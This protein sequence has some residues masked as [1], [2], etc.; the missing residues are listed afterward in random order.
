VKIADFGLANILSS[1]AARLP[2][3]EEPETLAY[4]APEQLSGNETGPWTDIY[5]LGAVMY[6]AISGQPPHEVVG[7]LKHDSMPRAVEVG[8]GR[9]RVELLQAVDWALALDEQARPQSLTEWREALLAQP[10]DILP[11]PKHAARERPSAPRRAE[12]W[13]FALP[14]LLIAAL[15]GGALWYYQA[16]GPAPLSVTPPPG[17]GIGEEAVRQAIDRYFEV[18]ARKDLDGLM[19]LYA[20]EVD[21]LGWSWVNQAA[22]RHDKEAFFARWPEIHYQLAGEIHRLEIS[23]PDETLIEFVFE[24]RVHNPATPELTGVSGQS[25][26]TWR[27]KQGKDG[28]KIVLHREKVLTRRK[29]DEP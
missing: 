17:V 18:T 24:Y 26:Y 25:K 7:R 23:Q 10:L 22:I 3:R 28:L 12:T 2:G 29:D 20:Q 19:A 14:A 6:H 4:R 9:Y 13:R 1:P 21:Y 8:A 11:R 27:L 16:A 15:T 5:A